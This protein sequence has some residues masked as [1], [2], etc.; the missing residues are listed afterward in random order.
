MI[1]GNMVGSYSQ[2]GKTFIITDE[3]GNELMGVVTDKEVVFTANAHRD[4]REGM[5]AA[6][7]EGIVVG[8]K[9]IPEYETTQES[10]LILP[11]DNYSISLSTHNKYDYTKLQCLIAKY[12]SDLDRMSVDKVV[13]DDNVYAVNSSVVLSSITK[14]ADTKSI[15][16]NM[17][18]DTNNIYIIYYF[19]YKEVD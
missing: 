10:L 17:S 3:D 15:D 16:L 12:N 7:D 4:I 2:I 14:N 1:N 9:I 5:I 6:T 8:E 11:G 19:T 18:N 13:I